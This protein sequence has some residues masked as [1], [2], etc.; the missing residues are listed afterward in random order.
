MLLVSEQVRRPSSLLPVCLRQLEDS[1][2][3]EP[4]SEHDD[5][6]VLDSLLV[7]CP[8]ADDSARRGERPRLRRT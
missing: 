2:L 4:D 7:A 1:R 5:A 6:A 3:F 8:E